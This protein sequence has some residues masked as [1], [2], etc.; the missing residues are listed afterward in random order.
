MDSSTSKALQILE[1]EKDDVKLPACKL[2]NQIISNIVANP[3]EEKF[4]HLNAEKIV[5]RLKQAKGAFE[6]ILALGFMEINTKY[7]LPM[8]LPL[9]SLQAVLPRI[10]QILQVQQQQQAQQQQAQ[11]QKGAAQQPKKA[12]GEKK[13]MTEFQKEHQKANEELDRKKKEREALRA[14]MELAKRDRAASC[15][16]PVQA[17]VANNLKFGS[18][19]RKFEPPPPS[20]GG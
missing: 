14:K 1:G 13:E 10:Q 2:L 12:V 11:E 4:R 5:P 19:L 9:G 17:S 18:Q 6:L 8:E 7:E 16:V 20:K 15:G 3:R